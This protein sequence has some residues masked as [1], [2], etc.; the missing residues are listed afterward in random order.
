MMA[1]GWR[2]V[3][4]RGFRVDPS[5]GQR[6][7]KFR[8]QCKRAL[9]KA[10]GFRT[11]I[12]PNKWYTTECYSQ[13]EANKNPAL[14]R[15]RVNPDT[16]KSERIPKAAGGPY[17]S[18]FERAQHDQAYRKTLEKKGVYTDEDIKE[19]DTTAHS[20]ASYCPL[21]FADRKLLFQAALKRSTNTSDGILHKT[22]LKIVTNKNLLKQDQYMQDFAIAQAEER[23]RRVK[24]SQDKIVLQDLRES[25]TSGATRT[26]EVRQHLHPRYMQTTSDNFAPS[27][28]LRS[29]VVLTPARS[30]EGHSSASGYTDRGGLSTR[31]Q[32]H[33]HRQ[34]RSRSPHRDERRTSSSRY[35]EGHS[36][37]SWSRSAGRQFQHPGNPPYISEI[38]ED[39]DNIMWLSDLEE[40][41]A[42]AE[43]CRYRSTSNEYYYT[44]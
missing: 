30:G 11:I 26:G 40:D 5:T 24:S 7:T 28:T 6:R 32:P 41:D 19:M 15:T 37:A 9:A 16:G 27:T 23:C 18:I 29:P 10:T 14:F 2:I 21:M 20:P 17:K 33:G 34:T 35:G 36:S 22:H 8:Q 4:L 25:I 39:H 44:R 31:D 42:G 3:S 38:P 13:A 43:I 12:N 1:L